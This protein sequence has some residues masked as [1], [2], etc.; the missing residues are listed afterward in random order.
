MV[1][2]MSDIVK[3]LRFG[4]L[5]HVG[6]S[7]MNLEAADYIEKLE[8]QLAAADELAGAVDEW[9]NNKCTVGHIK[10]LS[11]RYREARK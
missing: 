1:W 3:R 9:L 6:A 11:D 8:A 7:K 5:T 2:E 4:S 10:R